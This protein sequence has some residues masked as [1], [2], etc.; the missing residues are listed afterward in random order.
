[1]NVDSSFVSSAGE[2]QQVIGVRSEDSASLPSMEQ[3]KKDKKIRK[4]VAIVDDEE[5]LLS[6]FSLLFRN[7]GYVIEAI[8]RNGDEIIREIKDG[9]RPDVIIMDYRMPRMNGLQAATSVRK[10]LPDV[11]IV[12]A[13]ADDSIREAVA[14]EGLLFLSK[15][16]AISALIQLIK[17]RP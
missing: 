6:V 15:P 10:E 12:I 7:L 3:K 8:A 4:R 17:D 11:M 5:D 2:L 14:S 16:F 9:K 1:M 13:S